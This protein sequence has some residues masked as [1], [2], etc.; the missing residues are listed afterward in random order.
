M[1]DS[2]QQ[3]SEFKKA[4]EICTQWKQG[5]L[6]TAKELKGDAA[7]GTGCDSSPENYNYNLVW[8]ADKC[9][10][11]GGED[12]S[13]AVRGT[14]S[15]PGPANSD[16]CYSGVALLGVR[17]CGDVDCTTGD[18]PTKLELS[19]TIVAENAAYAE[20]GQLKVT[21]ADLPKD[22]HTFTVLNG[23]EHFAL[24]GNKLMTKADPIDY[25]KHGAVI[26][27]TIRVTDKGKRMLETKFSITIQDKND[28]PYIG[29][30]TIFVDENTAPGIITGLEVSR[31][32][33]AREYFCCVAVAQYCVYLPERLRWYAQVAALSLCVLFVLALYRARH[34]RLHP[35]TDRTCAC[36]LHHR[37]RRHRR[38]Y[39]T[40][41]YTAG[42]ALML[43]PTL[44]FRCACCHRLKTMILSQTNRG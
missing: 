14:G 13:L 8:T 19:S 25:E 6:C 29:T 15:G 22:S 38:H 20:V 10:T 3:H 34:F 12:G 31:C 16:R 42:M 18:P 37:H 32:C 35:R 40:H 23:G 9:K 11:S 24:V 28:A 7:K 2:C 30:T 33:A 27:V 26:A 36:R 21:D 39:P 1:S 41:F 5:R 44:V 4:T 17:C 43:T